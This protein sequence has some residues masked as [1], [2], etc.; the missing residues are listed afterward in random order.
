MGT[1]FIGGFFH[2]E[3][4]LYAG[5]K[6]PRGTFRVLGSFHDGFGAGVFCQEGRAGLPVVRFCFL[7]AVVVGVKIGGVVNGKNFRFFSLKSFADAGVFLCFH[8][9]P[10]S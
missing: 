1:V 10:L 2:Q 9:A 8:F 6:F 7:K 4:H 3:N 5:V